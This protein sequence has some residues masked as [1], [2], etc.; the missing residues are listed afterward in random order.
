MIFNISQIVTVAGV[1]IIESDV[2]TD[3]GV[4]HFTDYPLLR[5]AQGNYIETLTMAPLLVENYKFEAVKR[6]FELM[7]TIDPIQTEDS[8]EKT[9]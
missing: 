4:V 1:P 7:T 2:V 3:N 5:P 8:E 9:E 6:A